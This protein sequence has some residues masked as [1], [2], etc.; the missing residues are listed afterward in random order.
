V[1]EILLLFRYLFFE[2]L[3]EGSLRNELHADAL[4]FVLP[5]VE[6]LFA[7]GNGLLLHQSNLKTENN[8]K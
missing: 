8:L 6:K 3:F 1:R 2:L 4:V 7:L 5:F